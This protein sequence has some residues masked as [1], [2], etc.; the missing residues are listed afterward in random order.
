MEERL[1]K[2]NPWRKFNRKSP[3]YLLD[4]D[5]KIID[6]INEKEK[7]R[8]EHKID[9]NSLPVPFQGNPFN[10]KIILLQLNPGSDVPPG[11]ED[12]EDHALKV[13][14]KL[15]KDILKNNLR[16]ELEYSFYD[17]NPAYRL[18]GGFRYWLKVW[19]HFIKNKEDYKNIS[20][21]ICCIEFFPYHSRN[22]RP[23]GKILE[24]QK[25]NFGL[26]RQAISRKALIVIMKKGQWFEKVKEL[27]TYKNIIILKSRSPVLSQNNIS[28]NGFK[29]I[30]Q[31]LK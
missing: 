7:R 12:E 10:T 9:T 31:A 23:L 14:P 3:P 24:C 25:Y 18:Y 13:Y 28:R 17:L 16:E 5:K 4:E 26:V 11:F 15:K 2:I 22:Y 6:D 29:R 21:K 30:Q 1:N 20:K 8:P 27:K 19:Q